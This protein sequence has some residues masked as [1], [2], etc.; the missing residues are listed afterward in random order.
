MEA[1]L[2][3]DFTSP[4]SP[5]PAGDGGETQWSL[6]LK[7]IFWFILLPIGLVYLVKWLLHLS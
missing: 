4:S 1:V 3:A 7:A 5:P 6:A 2:M